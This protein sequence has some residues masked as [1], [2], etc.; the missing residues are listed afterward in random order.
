MKDLDLEPFENE[1]RAASGIGG[2]RC[3]AWRSFLVWVLIDTVIHPYFKH[4]VSHIARVCAFGHCN[5]SSKIPLIMCVLLVSL[6]LLFAD[7][8]G[9]EH[10]L[11]AL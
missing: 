5:T 1:W 2:L 3:L 7:G 8:F 11:G 4:A 10:D 9:L 6:V